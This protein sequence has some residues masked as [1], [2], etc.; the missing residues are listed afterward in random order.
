MRIII[1][2]S[3][4]SFEVNGH[5]SSDAHIK[6]NSLLELAIDAEYPTAAVEVHRGDAAVMVVYEDDADAELFDRDIVLTTIGQIENELYDA[7]EFWK[8]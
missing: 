8:A 7:G 6:Y 2:T 5:Y 1:P 3:R 4:E